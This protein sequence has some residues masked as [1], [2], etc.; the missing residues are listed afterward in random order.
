MPRGNL[1]ISVLLSWS[2]LAHC[3]V[4]ILLLSTNVILRIWRPTL[5]NISYCWMNIL[6][7]IANATVKVDLPRLTLP[8]LCERQIKTRSSDSIT[9][10]STGHI[11]ELLFVCL[12]ACFPFLFPTNEFLSFALWK[13]K[14]VKLSVCVCVCRHR[15]ATCMR[16]GQR[17]TSGVRLPPCMRQDLELLQAAHIRITVPRA[18]RCSSVSAP[19][20][21]WGH[22]D[23]TCVLLCNTQLCRS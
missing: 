10:R 20:L 1:S 5:Q 18:S 6:T 14:S 23:V 8:L 3:S 9:L 22:W 11:Y 12:F 4:L 16:G 2:V 19:W 7:L 17:A 21:S 13:L 15:L